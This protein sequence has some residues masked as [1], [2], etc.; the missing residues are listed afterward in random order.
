MS[1]DKNAAQPAMHKLL[2][3]AIAAVVLSLV[4]LASVAIGTYKITMGDMFACLTRT[5]SD[6]MV[7]QIIGRIRLPRVLTG[8]LAGMHLSVAGV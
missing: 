4:L 6:T 5:C 1:T 3:L 2:I 7:N 8:M